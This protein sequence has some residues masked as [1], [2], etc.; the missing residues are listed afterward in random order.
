M[1]I[2]RDQLEL[3]YCNCRQQLFTCAFVITGSPDLAED[4]VHE[5]FCTMCG[6]DCDPADLKAYVFRVVR[7][8]AITQVRR[9]ARSDESL[10]ESVFDTS[11]QPDLAVEETEFQQRIVG[12]LTKLNDDER[13]TIIQ[14]LFGELTFEEIAVVRER[15]LGT[16]TSWYR[17]GLQKLQRDLEVTHGSV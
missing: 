1:P 10:C 2:S 7:N 8:A 11:R 3:L 4:A 5:A 13:E 17:R 14:H 12:M 6:R 16:V 9:K 15:P